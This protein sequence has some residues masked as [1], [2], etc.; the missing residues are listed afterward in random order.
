MM[1]TC[2]KPETDRLHAHLEDLLA[3]PP[4][5]VTIALRDRGVA[6]EEREEDARGALSPE[7]LETLRRVVLHAAQSGTPEDAKLA[8]RMRVF[9][10]P[11]E[12]SWERILRALES[13]EVITVMVTEAVKGGL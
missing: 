6:A 8:A 1:P 4:E 5:N 7:A 11:R 9:L 13:G 2:E 3:S 10:D 12:R